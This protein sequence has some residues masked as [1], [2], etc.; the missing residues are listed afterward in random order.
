MK[1][2]DIDNMDKISD[3]D[4]KWVSSNQQWQS[5]VPLIVKMVIIDL[6]NY[7]ASSFLLDLHKICRL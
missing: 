7:V 3:R 6:V 2:A 1:L 5:C 4:R